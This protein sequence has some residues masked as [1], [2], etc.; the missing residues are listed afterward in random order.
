MER[1]KRLYPRSKV[2]WPVTM[3]T[4]VAT[5]EGE[6][7]DVSSLGAYIQCQEPLDPSENLFLSVRL[8]AGSPL[9]VFA[10]VVWS[11]SPG[12]ENKNGP[13]GMGVRFLW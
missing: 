6:T 9:H 1:D 3:T 10:E 2:R 11:N 5:V 7:K 13:P 12:L 8:L 4:S